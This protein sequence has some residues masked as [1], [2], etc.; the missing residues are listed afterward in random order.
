VERTTAL[1]EDVLAGA[2]AAR[3]RVRQ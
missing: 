1:Y 2:A 3:E